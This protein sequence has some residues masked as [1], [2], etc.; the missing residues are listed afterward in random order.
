MVEKPTR[1]QVFE[2]VLKAL[3]DICPGEPAAAAQAG[4]EACLMALAQRLGRHAAAAIAYEW[5]DIL[6][7]GGLE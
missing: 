5:A 7:A 1:I 4:A 3:E 6:V 2:A